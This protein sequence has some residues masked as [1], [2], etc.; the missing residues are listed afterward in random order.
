VPAAELESLVMRRLVAFLASGKAVLDAIGT[1][2]DSAAIRK[3]L[4]AA[5]RALAVD[6]PNA[7]SSELRGFLLATVTRVTLAEQW[8]NVTLSRRSLRAVLLGAPPAHGL[9]TRSGAVRPH[10]HDDEDLFHLRV[11]ARL[12]RS[13]AAVRL[14][15]APDT[16]DERPARRNESL[17]KA[18]A[19]AHVWYE[20]L[21]RGEVQSI[22]A[23]AA[24]LGV[25]ERYVSRILSCAFLAPDIVE[26]ILEGRQ[27]PQLTVEKLRFGA[28]LLWAEQRKQFGFT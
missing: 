6:L 20:R 21:V 22:P 17:I 18:V 10:D 13:G 27:P 2:D 28:P 4:I 7:P 8:L 5:G 11:E 26:A 24:E 16:A 15:L 12:E 1:P 25:N 9:S 3:A 19:R 23:I 14:V